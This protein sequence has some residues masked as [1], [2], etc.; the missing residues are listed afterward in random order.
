[1]T[2][3]SALLPSSA[4]RPLLAI[5]LIAMEQAP[6]APSNHLGDLA[7]SALL[8]DRQRCWSRRRLPSD[9]TC[10]VGFPA[11]DRWRK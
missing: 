4:T 7:S 6:L 10:Q 1:M 2:L 8:I 9:A 5:E 11:A 3:R